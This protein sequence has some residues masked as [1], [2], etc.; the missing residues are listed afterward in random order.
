LEQGFYIAGVLAAKLDKTGTV[1]MIGGD[2]VPSI[3]STFDAFS[4]GAKATKPQIKVLT[5]YTGDG[6]DVAKA[7][8]ATLNAI[9]QGADLVIHQADNA[10]QGVFEACKEKNV[11]AI[12]S[13]L[14]QNKNAT[15]I[16]I[17]SAI[18]AAG[19]AFVDLAKEVQAGTYK[20]SVANFGVKQGAIDFVI[21]PALQ[22]K[23]PADVQ[24]LLDDTKSKI[25]AGTLTVPE[26][27][28]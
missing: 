28:F 17:G 13:N 12:G 19:P 20:G 8:E 10:A 18:I 21:N 22:S 24:K 14:D 16:V 1:A 25:K 26:A 9:G 2:K 6:N 3:Q 7:K 27:K 23:V 15:G 11:Y 4:A 5:V